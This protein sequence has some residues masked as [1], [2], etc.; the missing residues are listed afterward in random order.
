MVV[1][2]LKENNVSVFFI[3]IHKYNVGLHV[4]FKMVSTW[5]VGKTSPEIL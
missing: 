3:N 2:L 5:N 4:F 1:N